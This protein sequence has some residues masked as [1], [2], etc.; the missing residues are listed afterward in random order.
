MRRFLTLILL[1]CF[2]ASCGGG[3]GGGGSPDSTPVD[4]APDSNSEPDP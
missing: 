2:L 1:A 4:D 3:G